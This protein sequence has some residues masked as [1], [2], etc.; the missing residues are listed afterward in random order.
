MDAWGKDEKCRRTG[1]K[2]EREKK[3]CIK[4]WVKFLEIEYFLG[5][6]TKFSTCR[7]RC[8]RLWKKRDLHGEMEGGRE[9]YR[10]A[11][12]IPLKKAKH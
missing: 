10:I 9:N 6:N 3:D 1:K 12:Y 8:E 5:I 2:I 4:N 11:Q 7:R